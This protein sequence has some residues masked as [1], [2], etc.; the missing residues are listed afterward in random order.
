VQEQIIVDYITRLDDMNMSLTIGL[1]VDVANRLL[2]LDAPSVGEHWFRR[3]YNRHLDLRTRRQTPIVVARKDASNI[4]LLELYF[5]KLKTVVD[6]KGIQD[7]N[8]WNMNEID[9][10]I[11]CERAHIVVTRSI[12]GVLQMADLKN[13]D[14]IMVVKAV[15]VVDESIPPMIIIKEVHI[16]AKWSANDIDDDTLFNTSDISY[17]NDDL[18]IDWL[19]H[20]IRCT[21]G[22][23]RER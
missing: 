10:R 4:E 9:F 2:S 20:F 18:A 21:Q 19:R 16:L 13:R 22:K 3:F 8:H 7:A 6:E 12:R 23:R 17:S 14:Y 1:V 11:G 5:R 15:S